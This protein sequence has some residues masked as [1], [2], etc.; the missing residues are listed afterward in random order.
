[1]RHREQNEQLVE[2]TDDL[3]RWNRLECAGGAVSPRFPCV[4]SQ[5]RDTIRRLAAM[6]FVFGSEPAR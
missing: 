5:P 4:S 3:K 1:M 6:A 2:L